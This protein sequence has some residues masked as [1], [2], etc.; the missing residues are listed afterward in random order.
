M[1]KLD[2]LSLIQIKIRINE[3][4]SLT[5]PTSSSE[6]VSLPYFKINASELGIG[7]YKAYAQYFGGKSYSTYY[8]SYVGNYQEFAIIKPISLTYNTTNDGTQF[9]I[10]LKDL[11]TNNSVP[12]VKLRCYIIENAIIHDYFYR[13]DEEVYTDENGEYTHTL[14][15]IYGKHNYTITISVLS[16]LYTNNTKNKKKV[17]F[18]TLNEYNV[19][20]VTPNILFELGDVYPNVDYN[21]N[22]I[23]YSYGFDIKFPEDIKGYFHL[24]ENSM[25]E[26]YYLASYTGRIIHLFKQG[27]L[28]DNYIFEYKY[29]GDDKYSNITGIYILNIPKNE[30]KSDKN[31]SN[32][33]NKDKK[34]KAYI[35]ML[36]IQISSPK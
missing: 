10:K 14:D 28:G 13:F 19:P 25:N 31:D 9:S 34:L 23:D 18:S 17:A 20:Y 35:Y 22:V 8:E 32:N 3:V 12:N 36:K 30:S 6:K 5:P 26:T 27:N 24:S 11:H 29:D 33:P 16:D 15:N 4:I 21:G 7:N 2:S 1:E